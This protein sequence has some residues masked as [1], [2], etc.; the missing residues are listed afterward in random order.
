MKWGSTFAVTVWLDQIF[1]ISY[2]KKYF[3]IVKMKRNYDLTIK[4]YTIYNSIV[5]Y[6]NFTI[7][8]FLSI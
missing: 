8:W 4:G 6:H 3:D 1:D 7:Q 2:E 5:L